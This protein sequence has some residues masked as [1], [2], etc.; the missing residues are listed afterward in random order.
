MCHLDHFS[1]IAGG[2]L[3]PGCAAL[4]HRS[5]HF[6]V[7]QIF[8]LTPQVLPFAPEIEVTLYLYMCVFLAAWIKLSTPLASALGL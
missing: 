3:H 2:F 1:D 5:L 7:S 8:A 6:K 4:R